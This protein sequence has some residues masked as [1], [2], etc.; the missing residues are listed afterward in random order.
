MSS[1]FPDIQQAWLILNVVRIFHTYG[2]LIKHQEKRLHAA[3]EG[4]SL[5]VM[6]RVMAEWFP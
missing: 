5:S 1:S 4:P 3:E 6:R 2:G